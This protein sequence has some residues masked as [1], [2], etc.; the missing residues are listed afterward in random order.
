MDKLKEKMDITVENGIFRMSIED[1]WEKCKNFSKYINL[2]KIEDTFSIIPSLENLEK[3]LMLLITCS[4]KDKLGFW[5]LQYGNFILELPDAFQKLV[6]SLNDLNFEFRILEHIFR[7][8]PNYSASHLEVAYIGDC[9]H[10]DNI[11][12]HDLNSVLYGEEGFWGKRH[13]VRN[14]G[15]WID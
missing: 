3:R 2:N 13:V 8:T 1:I 10:Y 11:F 7:V 14:D 5:N 15:F 6:R 4:L 9:E 12:M